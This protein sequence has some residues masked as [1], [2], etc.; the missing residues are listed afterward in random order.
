MTPPA[1]SERPALNPALRDG[2]IVC[3][4]AAAVAC[5]HK[6]IAVLTVDWLHECWRSQRRLPPEGYEFPFLCGQVRV[7][8]ARAVHELLRAA[9]A[10]Y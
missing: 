3:R 8:A 4:Y 6:G 1:K 9:L 7:G 5:A 10:G 2:D